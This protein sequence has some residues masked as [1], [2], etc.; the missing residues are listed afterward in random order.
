M[1]TAREKAIVAMHEALTWDGRVMPRAAVA[2]LVNDI[3]A[4]ANEEQETILA[5]LAN[6]RLKHDEQIARLVRIADLHNV[7]QFTDAE[8]II[9]ALKAE[10]DV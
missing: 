1:A 2:V 3:L 4:A 6:A 10:R 7:G 5:Q 8:S 9:E